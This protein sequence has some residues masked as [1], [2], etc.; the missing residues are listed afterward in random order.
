M[1]GPEKREREREKE[2]EKERGGEGEF[3][4]IRKARMLNV[5]HPTSCPWFSLR[6]FVYIWRSC[7]RK[8]RADIHSSDD[9]NDSVATYHRRGNIAVPWSAVVLHSGRA[10][11]PASISG[12]PLAHGTNARSA[13]AWKHRPRR[14][15]VAD[16]RTHVRKHVQ[17]RGNKGRKR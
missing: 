9:L 11:T 5:H 7:E 16:G 4:C 15:R 17:K 2:K 10:P 1:N 13:L 12:W 6:S 8:H 14:V 3:G